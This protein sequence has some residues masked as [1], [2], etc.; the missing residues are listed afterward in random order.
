MLLFGETAQKEGRAG[1]VRVAT[2]PDYL[3]HL[4]DLDPGTYAGPV[5]VET[6]ERPGY[7]WVKLYEKVPEKNF[8]REDLD[9][10]RIEWINRDGA[11]VGAVKKRAVPYDGDGR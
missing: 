2:I 1:L 5:N 10:E 3:A 9:E 4:A 8:K 7:Y 11:Q 6:G